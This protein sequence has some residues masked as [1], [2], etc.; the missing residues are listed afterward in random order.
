MFIA[1]GPLRNSAKLRRSGMVRLAIDLPAGSNTRK[2]AAPTELGRAFGAVD[3]I[4]M[5]LLTELFAS[6][7][8]EHFAVNDPCNPHNPLEPP[9][10]NYYYRYLT[11][12]QPHNHLLLMPPRKRIHFFGVFSCSAALY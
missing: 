5:A 9:L 4:S 3:S 8:P 2:H 12:R 6:P 1:N 10:Q 11:I 7:A